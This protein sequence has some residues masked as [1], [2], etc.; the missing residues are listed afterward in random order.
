VAALDCA[1][2]SASHERAQGELRLALLQLDR[3][4]EP[5]QVE[6]HRRIVEALQAHD[7]PRAAQ[8]LAAH[9]ETAAVRLQHLVRVKESQ[10]PRKE[11]DQ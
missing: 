5:P 6:E 3:N 2:L 10:P 4:Y 11:H 1:R 8:A 7:L 9:L